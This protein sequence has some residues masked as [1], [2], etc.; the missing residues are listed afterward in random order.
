MTVLEFILLS[1]VIVVAFFVSELS[2]YD[3]IK[4]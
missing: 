2:Y 1:F 3:T 4:N